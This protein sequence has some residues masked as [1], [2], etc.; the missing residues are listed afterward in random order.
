MK[1]VQRDTY[2]TSPAEEPAG[3]RRARWKTRPDDVV[4]GPREEQIAN[5]FFNGGLHPLR[6]TDESQQQFP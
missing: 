3:S 6:R 5:D 1:K 4:C 2:H